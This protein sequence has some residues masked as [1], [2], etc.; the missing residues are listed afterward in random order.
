MNR[1][2][3]HLCVFLTGR[4]CP[5]CGVRKIVGAPLT[6]FEDGNMGFGVICYNRYVFYRSIDGEATFVR[7]LEREIIESI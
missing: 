6:R 1:I 3:F 2:F 4:K 7:F 5:K